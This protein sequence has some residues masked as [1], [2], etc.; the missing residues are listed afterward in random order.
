MHLK[1]WRP[2]KRFN[3]K[4]AKATKCHYRR[5]RRR[6]VGRQPQPRLVA[7]KQLFYVQIVKVCHPAG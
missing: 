5:R 1:P 2:P 7:P 4:M 3:I 6:K